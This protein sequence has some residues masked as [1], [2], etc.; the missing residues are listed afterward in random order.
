MPDKSLVKETV[1]YL[2]KEAWNFK[3]FFFVFFIAEII[4]RGVLPFTYIV[5][6]KYLIDQF[7]GPRNLSVIVMLAGL[8]IGANV[9]IN[10]VIA[11]TNEN[12]QKKYYPDI[13]MLLQA[14]L[15]RKMM[16]IP[17]EYTENKEKLDKSEKAKTGIDQGYSGG[18]QG[19]TEPV[20]GIVTAALVLAGC[21]G[22]L[23]INTPIVI[24]L[25]IANVGFNS[26]F[27][28]RINRIQLKLF[29]KKSA[30]NRAFYYC[31]FS[32]ADF[33]YGKDIRLYN[34]E[35]MM[36]EK[37]DA[38][39]RNLAHINKKQ[40]FQLLPFHELSKINLAVITAGIYGYIGYSALTGKLGIGDC[41]MLIAA[42][43]AM[44][45]NINHIIMQSQELK[46]KCSYAFE[47]VDFMQTNDGQDT[48]GRNCIDKPHTIEFRDVSFAYPGTDTYIL[49]N[50]NLVLRQGE[51]LSIVGKNGA[52]KTTFIKLLCRFYKVSE[53]QILLDGID[54]NEYRFDDYIKLLSVVFQ[55][56]SLLGY[57]LKE[58]I[59]GETAALV[60]DNALTPLLEQLG[61]DKKVNELPLRL[62]TP[63]FKYY[64][65]NGFEPS[66][67]EQQKI[68][69]AR[70][71]YKDAPLII[72]D[73]PTAALDPVAEF[74]I[75]RQFHTMVEDKTAVYISHRLSSCKFCKNIAV[76]NNGRIAEY[77]CHAELIKIKNGIYAEMFST[78]A[79]YY[80]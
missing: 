24:L 33:R 18:I 6:P 57:S 43:T 75:Y 16:E 4:L 26:F 73:E 45:E 36:L 74:E 25:I 3:P 71:I 14:K 39:N 61:L 19:V 37:A 21:T 76:F 64:D 5:I 56:F 41:T 51:P 48:G 54:I 23:L 52:G 35:D 46:K 30:I 27:N 40:A 49:E 15:G 44:S 69:I 62:E 47:Y 9:I 7:T 58:N 42:A 11:W 31:L 38:Y 70:A 80:K 32:L 29:K 28:S 8:M 2:L 10:F 20:M 17:Y 63:V 68:A 22:I 60:D 13:Q 59:A 66:G 53:G 78:Q 65:K 79:Q 67:G 55:D 12:I 50:I 1:P 77:G 34:A 72:L